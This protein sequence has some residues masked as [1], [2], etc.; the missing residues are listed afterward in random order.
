MIWRRHAVAIILPLSVDWAA[1]WYSDGPVRLTG[2]GLVPIGPKPARHCETG[3]P[4]GAFLAAYEGNRSVHDRRIRTCHHACPN[5]APSGLARCAP[6]GAERC[7]D[8]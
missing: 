4:G 1:V 3:G 6:P 8:R 2:V 7:R 5:L